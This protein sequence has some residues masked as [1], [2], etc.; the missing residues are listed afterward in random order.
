MSDVDEH[1]MR[2]LTVKP[3]WHYALVHA[4][5]DVENRSTN[6]AG[7]YRGPV[8]IHAGL[9]EDDTAYD[10]PMIAQM[11]RERDGMS[12]LWTLGL[13][14]AIV[15]VVDLVDVHHFGECVSIDDYYEDE[16]GNE[17]GNQQT[18]ACSEWAEQADVYHLVFANP[19]PLPRPIPFI[20]GQG[21]RWLRSEST[22][23]EID[24]QLRHG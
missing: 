5:K 18:Y 16:D 7:E 15:G 13:R 10:H 6:I 12:P 1:P 23:Q 2:I 22:K 19:R 21:L 8:A 14:G 20:G 11:V 9:T 4:G 3:P 24:W 17:V